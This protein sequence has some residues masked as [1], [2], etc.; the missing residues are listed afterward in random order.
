MGHSGARGAWNWSLAEVRVAGDG[1]QWGGG[2]PVRAQ[3]RGTG[4]GSGKEVR[5]G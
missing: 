5:Q 4:R 3:S 1:G 2:G